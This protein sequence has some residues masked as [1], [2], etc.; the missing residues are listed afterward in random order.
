MKKYRT[1]VREVEAIQWNK[2]NL[3]EIETVFFNM[4]IARTLRDRL[5]IN[6]QEVC[7]GDYIVQDANDVISVLDAFEFAAK[8]EPV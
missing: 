1:R 7:V 4:T 5:L 6:T 2:S 8:Y 3:D